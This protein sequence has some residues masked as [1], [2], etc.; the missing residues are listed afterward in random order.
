MTD[1]AYT[2]IVFRLTAACDLTP[3]FKLKA[4]AAWV[5]TSATLVI[6]LEN[7]LTENIYLAAGSA[8]NYLRVAADQ[9]HG[10]PASTTGIVPAVHLSKSTA[11][12]QAVNADRLDARRSGPKRVKH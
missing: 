11:S 2:D 7:P 10:P 12:R 4:R 5:R 9:D 8:S 6:S 3:S 1:Q